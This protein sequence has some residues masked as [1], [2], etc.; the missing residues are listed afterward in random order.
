[1]KD[2]ELRELLRKEIADRRIAEESE[3][4]SG[5]LSQ[6]VHVSWEHLEPETPYQHNW[7]VDAICEHLEAVSRG[8][9]KRLQVWVPPQ[10]MKSRLVSILWPAW[11]WTFAPGTKYWTASYDNHLAGNLASVSYNLMNSTWYQER[12]GDKFRFTRDAEHFFSN[13]RG[14]HRLA[15]S[16]ESKGTGYH[17]HRII[18]DDALRAQQDVSK[19]DLQKVNDWYDGTVTSRGL[20]RDHARIL[21]MQ[22]LHQEDIAAHLL[23][24]EDWVVLA[25][26]EEYWP[27]HPYA[28]RGSRKNLPEE[29]EESEGSTLG[30]GDPRTEEDELLWE[31]R[32]PRSLVEAQKSGLKYRA[33]GQLQQWPTPREGQLLKRNW[34]RFYDPAI[35]ADAKRRPRCNA[36][37]QTIDTP[38]KDKESNDFVAMQVWGVKGADRY[39]IDLRKGHMNYS[40]AKRAAIEQAQYARRLYPRTAH[41]IL[42]ENA[43]Y[44]VELIID[45]KRVLTGVTKVSPT[46]DGDKIMRAE[47]ASSDLESGNCWL[48]G[49]GGGADETLGP[50]KTAS[51]DVTDFIN[52]LAIFPN[53]AHDD[54]VDAWSQCMNWLRSRVIARGR[55]SSPFKRRRAGTVA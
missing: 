51:A 22:R 21:V 27:G 17:G 50:A 3:Q 6:F 11:E 4:L 28:W 32:R 40:Q 13:N 45:L 35:L 38:L 43:G 37:V 7:H 44:G 8:Q 14:G 36:V 15:T 55:T 42:I 25:L 54:D 24:L 23:E 41:Y 52:N 9:I 39:L 29:M 34:W 48:P 53:G 19:V 12:W 49:I 30:A 20:G 33:S 5:S 31:E 16:P 2:E 47:A 26:P 18:L 46:Q 10:S 1:V